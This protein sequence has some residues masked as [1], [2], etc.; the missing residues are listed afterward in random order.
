MPRKKNRRPGP[1]GVPLSVSI[2][3]ASVSVASDTP[4]RKIN[5][6][7]TSSHHAV[8]AGPVNPQ[9][10]NV[11]LLLFCNKAHKRSTTFKTASVDPLSPTKLVARTDARLREPS[12]KDVP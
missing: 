9:L 1:G 7:H 3:G 10:R 4:L 2:N 5:Y 8:F 6:T 11:I 12:R